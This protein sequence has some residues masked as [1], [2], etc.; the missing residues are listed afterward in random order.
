M[1]LTD[2]TDAYGSQALL[3]GLARLSPRHLPFC[4][5]L[6]D[7]S[8]ETLAVMPIGEMPQ[9][10]T[11]LLYK[12]AAAIDLKNQRELALSHLQRRGCVVLDSA[13]Q[14]LSTRIVDSYL[15]L[16]ARARL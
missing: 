3:N 6:K 1:V 4:V 13:P 7:K 10:E 12:R 16:K 9:K 11:Q 2:L 14:D 15:D 5:T 8:I